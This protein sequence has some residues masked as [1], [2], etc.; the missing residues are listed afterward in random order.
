MGRDPRTQGADQRTCHIVTQGVTT[1]GGTTPSMGR[2]PDCMLSKEIFDRGRLF[3]WLTESPLT[4]GRPG[5]GE[6]ERVVTG[7][8]PLQLMPGTRP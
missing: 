4:V 3:T 8:T 6:F 1:V 2:D 5:S 7:E